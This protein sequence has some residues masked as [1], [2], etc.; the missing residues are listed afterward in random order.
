MLC[1]HGPRRL[2]KSDVPPPPDTLS[3]AGRI[4][5]EAARLSAQ[6]LAAVERTGLL[7]APPTAAL[8]RLTRLA[9]SLID[10]PATFI[11]LVADK[12]DFYVSQC[13]LPEPLATGR[14]LGGET[15][16]HY[17]I[18]HDG[19]LAIE[20][21]RA[22]PVYRDVAT[23]ESLGVAA[24]LGVPM[25]AADGQVIG[26][27]CAIDFKP[28][29]WTERDKAVMRELATSALREMALLESIGLHLRMADEAQL[30]RLAAER[31]AQAR[32][33]I[34]HSVSHDLR[35]PLNTLFLALGGVAATLTDER[36][37]KPLEI[38]RRQVARMRRLIDDLLDVARIDGGKM[39]VDSKPIEV[40]PL[41][42]EIAGDFAAQA[43]AAG[44]A[45]AVD[46][47]AG[48]PPMHADHA[49]VVQVFGNVVSN[50][51]RFTPAGGRVT[52][53][54]RSVDGMMRLQ[55]ADTGSGIDPVSL[56]EIFAPFWQADP[57]RRQGAGLGLHIVRGIVEAH[58]GTVR[59][60]S[61]LGHG[62]TFEIDLPLAPAP[63]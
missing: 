51:L 11:S 2:S 20:D 62:T 29:A 27:F 26:S 10:V 15:F 48:L 25:V 60:R 39:H 45:V 18:V 28:R 32:R 44:V 55:V 41:L 37:A 8:D 35:D 21:T 50:A 53:A 14:E 13:G 17:A 61:R 19:V 24:Y 58:G 7:D 3:P 34:L 54:A 5:I 40:E 52:L 16:C 59:A 43:Q 42:A 4:S 30:A 47:P 12:R 31:Q 33:D 38:A 49:R 36:A 6:R 1:N 63:S 46:V 57:S 22:H 9:A 56:P 23:V